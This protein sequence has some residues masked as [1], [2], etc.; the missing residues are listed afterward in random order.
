M[1]PRYIKRIS[2]RDFPEEVQK[3]IDILLYPLNASI[4]QTGA[5]LE[6]NIS[7]YDNLSANVRTLQVSGCSQIKGDTTQGSNTILNA[8]YYQ[9][10]IEGKNYGVQIG[11]PIKGLGL[12]NDTT[13]TNIVGSTITLSKPCN[14]TQKEAEFLSGGFFPVRIAYTLD[15]RPSSVI[16]SNITDLEGNPTHISSGVTP[17]WRLENKEVV[18]DGISGLQAG[19][20]YSVT[21]VIL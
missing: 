21:F 17:Q 6:K 11:Q 2:K 10:T 19:K 12:A 20:T 16:I 3:W 13:I 1:K 15:F 8:S 14:Y 5:I 9:A 18:I 7:L 4:E